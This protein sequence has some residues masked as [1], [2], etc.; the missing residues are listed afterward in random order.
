MEVNQRINDLKNRVAQAIN[1]SQLPAWTVGLVL[2]SV[3]GQVALLEVQAV[4]QERAASKKAAE[5]I[6][7]DADS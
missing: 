5:K 3:R 6:N 2:E 1:A 7:E 4:E